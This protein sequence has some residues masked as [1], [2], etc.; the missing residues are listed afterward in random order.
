TPVRIIVCQRSKVVCWLTVSLLTPHHLFCTCFILRAD[1]CTVLALCTCRERSV[2]LSQCFRGLRRRRSVVAPVI[3]FTRLHE[4][5]L[6]TASSA[7]RHFVVGRVG[8]G[9]GLRYVS[10]PVCHLSL[11]SY[12]T[13]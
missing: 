5:R 9:R 8:R 12:C 2:F 3:C 13:V 6:A 10:S 7:S 4:E 1:S 11:V